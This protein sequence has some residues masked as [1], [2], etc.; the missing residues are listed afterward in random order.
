MEAKFKNSLKLGLVRANKLKMRILNECEEGR[1]TLRMCLRQGREQDAA[2]IANTIVMGSYRTE[3]LSLV[4]KY[5][6]TLSGLAVSSMKTCGESDNDLKC[7]V[8]SLVFASPYF[9]ELVELTECRQSLI[10]IFGKGY[11]NET[12]ARAVDPLLS[13]YANLPS[14][15]N[16]F[17]VI[18]N[19]VCGFAKENRIDISSLPL[20]TSPQHQHQ[21]QSLSTSQQSLSSSQKQINEKDKEKESDKKEKDKETTKKLQPRKTEAKKPFSFFNLFDNGK[22]GKSEIDPTKCVV[23]KDSLKEFG[24]ADIPTRFT[25]Q[26]NDAAGAP[27]ICPDLQSDAFKVHVLVSGPE[28]C[29]I[30]GTYTDNKD[31]T[32]TGEFTPHTPGLYAIAVYCGKVLLGGEA[33]TQKVKPLDE[34]RKTD[35]AKCTVDGPGL[36]APMVND[37]AVFTVTAVDA[38]GDRRPGGADKISVLISG[39]CGEHIVGDVDDN[40]DGTYTASFLPVNKGKYAIAVYCENKLIGNNGNPFV[41][42]FT[43]DITECSSFVVINNGQDDQTKQNTLDTSESDIERKDKKDS[44]MD[45]IEVES[46]DDSKNSEITTEPMLCIASGQGLKNGGAAQEMQTFTIRAINS[47]GKQ[48]LRGGDRFRVFISGPNDL[49]IRGKV[50]DLGN[51]TYTAAYVPPVEGLYNIAVYMGSV[52]LGEGKPIQVEVAASSGRDGG[53]GGSGSGGDEDDLE[54][55]KRFKVLHDPLSGVQSKPGY[56]DQKKKSAERMKKK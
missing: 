18:Q 29:R 43:N 27:C 1:V 25:I 14:A 24:A 5:M 55:M 4:I 22:K 15:L 35:P 40:G 54:L 21:Q 50:H 2:K 12:N 13:A 46:E 45:D 17:T 30:V 33:L 42:N 20:F 44:E 8:Q 36:R 52:P 9:P 16:D 38:L 48:R 10:T 51:G 37:L 53:D 3:A 31:G 26:L 41:V 28:G 23:V 19:F 47:D 49:R 56:L 39:P 7:A 32:L 6:T 34:M 11:F